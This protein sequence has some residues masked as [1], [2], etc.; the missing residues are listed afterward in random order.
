VLEWSHTTIPE[1]TQ[2]GTVE[3]VT[4][5]VDEYVEERTMEDGT[6]IQPPHRNGKQPV[7]RSPC[8]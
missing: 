3:D 6:S 5:R 4:E 8:R 2:E 7:A 1:K